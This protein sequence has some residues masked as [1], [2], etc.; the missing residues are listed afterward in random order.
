MKPKIPSLVRL[1]ICPL[2]LTS[3]ASAQDGLAVVK[4]YYQQAIRGLQRAETRED[5]VKLVEA[6]DSPDWVS[7]DPAGFVVQTRA[8][9]VSSLEPLLSIPPDKRP[10]PKIE[11]LW[12]REEPWRV[13]AVSI[14]LG[15]NVASPNPPRVASKSVFGVDHP[16]PHFTLA[17]TLIRDTFA[18]TSAGWLRVKHEKLLPDEFR[19]PS[20][21]SVVT[22]DPR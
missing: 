11:V 14:V 18:R 5:L 4:N 22:V 9:A 21:D 3:I 12:I 1:L 16:Q 2:I 13:T 6:G 19:V 17:G 20:G 7:I 8:Q 10:T 15:P